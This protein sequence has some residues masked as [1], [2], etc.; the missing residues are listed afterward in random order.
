MSRTGTVDIDKLWNTK[1]NELSTGVMR[2]ANGNE[3]D[4]Q[5]GLIGIRDGLLRDPGAN[6]SYLLQA[7]KF[8]MNNRR[9]KGKSVD[10]GSKYPTTATL[11]DG[12]VKVYRKDMRAIHLDAIGHD[13]DL[14]PYSGQ[15][16]TLAL[17]RVCSERFYA[18][19]DEEEMQFVEAG[20]QTLGYRTRSAMGISRDEYR[21]IRESTYNKFICAFGTDEE[22]ATVEV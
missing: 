15:P 6:D 9:N 3:D 16:D 20:I 14:P 5:E 2:I 1:V 7:A 10:N 21:R 4:Y 19:L 8:A 22:L 12:T 13:L 17:D 18:M 11:L